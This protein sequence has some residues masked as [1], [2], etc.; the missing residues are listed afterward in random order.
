MPFAEVWLTLLLG[1]HDYQLRRT[2]DDFYSASDIEVVPKSDL[3]S[4][5][6]N[7]LMLDEA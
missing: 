3:A 1:D 5:E 7:E 4:I 2:G 6:V